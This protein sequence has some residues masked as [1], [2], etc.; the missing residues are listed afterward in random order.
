M[1][2]QTKRTP[3]LEKQRGYMLLAVM[4]LITLMLI[5]MS[6]ELPR[7]AQQ[8]KRDKEQE[9]VY[10]GMEYARA[11]KK[12][13][14]KMGAYPVSID[15]LKDTNHIRFLRKEYKDPITGESEWKLVHL[16][17]AEIKIPTPLGQ[18]GSLQGT[19]PGL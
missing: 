12:Y 8:I 14:H 7:I 4:L 1:V 18:Q 19:N 3:Q 2:R 6:V 15:Q 5:A 10:R 17:E 13:Y 9:L 16:G 11:V